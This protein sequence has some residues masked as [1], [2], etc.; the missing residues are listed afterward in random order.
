MAGWSIPIQQGPQAPRPGWKLRVLTG[1]MLGHE[2]DLPQSRY[3]LGSRPPA[4]IVVGDPSIAPRHLTIDIYPDHI[5]L[6]DCSGGAGMR[7]ND[8]RV[9]ACRVV[10]GDHIT[11]GVFKF[12]FS[13]P[14]YRPPPARSPDSL[15]NTLTRLPLFLRVGGVAFA[16]A[17]LLYLLL[18]LTGE[19]NLVPVTLLAMSAAVPATIIC[20]LVEKYDRTGISFFTLVVTFLAGGTVGVIAAVIGFIVGG[21]ATLN[22]LTGPVFAGLYEEPAKF[23]G[24]AWRSRHPKYDRPMDGLILGT[25]SGVGFAV[26]ETAGYGFASLTEEEGGLGAVLLTMVVRGLTSP[27]AHGIWAGILAAAF[28]QCGRDLP[29]AFRSKEFWFAVLWAVGLHAIWNAGAD[30]SFLLMLVSGGLGVWQYRQLLVQKGYRKGFL[31]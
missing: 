29:R 1:R 22:Q 24:T 18:A 14:T 2:F 6:R 23:L 21:V 8:R 10:P 9:R 15:V 4:D 28:W 20:F 13:N 7:V 3:V 19:P 30:V 11:V 31:A 5:Q 27:F 25:V 17:G 12:E 26:F 16:V